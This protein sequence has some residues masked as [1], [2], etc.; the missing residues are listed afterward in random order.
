MNIILIL[1]NFFWN[2][3]LY[4]GFVVVFKCLKFCK[5]LMLLDVLYNNINWNGVY[6]IFKGLVV[7]S[8]L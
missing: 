1:F 2:G 8:M 5:I 6:V 3:L 4:D 7:N